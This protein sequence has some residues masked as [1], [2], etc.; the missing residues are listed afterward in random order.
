L[1]RSPG[2]KSQLAINPVAAVIRRA[3][4]KEA[5]GRQLAVIVINRGLFMIT[6]IELQFSYDGQS[7]VAADPIMAGLPGGY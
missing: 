1:H 2:K 5:A 7:L 4:K 6:T 3:D